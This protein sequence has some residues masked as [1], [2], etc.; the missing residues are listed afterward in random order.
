MS[1]QTLH[2]SGIAPAHRSLWDVFTS[3]FASVKGA[4]G[5]R[6]AY[7]GLKAWQMTDL[8]LNDVKTMAANNGETSAMRAIRIAG[9]DQAALAALSHKF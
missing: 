2:V 3:M 7:H 4:A 5:N 6:S 9:A 8:G 1:A